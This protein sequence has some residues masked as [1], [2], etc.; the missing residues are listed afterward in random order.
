MTEL[1]DATWVHIS[2]R[3]A[4]G[5]VVIAD[6]CLQ[7]VAGVLQFREELHESLVVLAESE[8]ANRNIMRE[9]I[10]TIDEGDLP[11]VTLYRHELSVHDEEAAETFR[12][13]VRESDLVVVGQCFQFCNDPSVGR[14]NTF[15]DLSCQC[16]D[17]RALEM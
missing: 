9:V 2:G 1:D 6:E 3:H 8:H 15:V 14:I 4:D 17:A 12:V 13:A 5:F 7:V 10:D 16:T 11:I